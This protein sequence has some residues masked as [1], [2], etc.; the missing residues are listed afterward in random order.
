QRLIRLYLHNGAIGQAL[1]QYHQF[2]TELRHELGLTPSPETQGLVSAALTSRYGTPI[3][4]CSPSPAGDHEGP[5]YTTQPP[6]PLQ[7]K[8]PIATRRAF[9]V[10]P[11]VGRDG[12]FQKLLT[13]SQAAGGGRGSAVLIQGEDGIGRSRLLNELAAS[14]LASELSW[15][16][17]Q[18]SCSPFDGLLSYG[19]FLEAFQIADLGD[20]ID[21]PSQAR[22]TDAG[23]QSRVLWSILQALRML[24]RTVPLLL[25]IDD[26]QSANSPTLHLFCF[27]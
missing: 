10:L 2:E 8:K 22:E 13:I 7:T 4:P 17:L 11:F 15:M 19:P 5:P 24:T 12:A 6:S 25:S 26:L 18:G 20:L 23:E 16:I 1:R 14:L 21:L 9:E 3:L 27:L